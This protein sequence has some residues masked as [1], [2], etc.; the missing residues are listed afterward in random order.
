MEFALIH[1]PGPAWDTTLSFREQ[2]LVGLHVGHMQ[3]LLES[4]NLLLGGPFLDDTGGLCVIRGDSA[5]EARRLAESDPSLAAG[6]LTVEIHPWL[7]AMR[8]E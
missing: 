6:L 5:D 3:A 2:P 1:R 8:A 4:G 7:I